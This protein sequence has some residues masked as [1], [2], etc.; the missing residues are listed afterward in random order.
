MRVPV[1]MFGRFFMLKNIF[2]IASGLTV[3][4]RKDKVYYLKFAIN[5]YE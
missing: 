3:I 1:K 2:A 5:F 4:K